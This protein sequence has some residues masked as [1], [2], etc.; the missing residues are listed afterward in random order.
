MSSLHR[1]LRL[2][3]VAVFL[4]SA[5]CASSSAVRYG[6]VAYAPLPAE[7]PVAVFPDDAS[8]GQPYEVIGEV[9]VDNPGKWQVLVASDAISQLSRLAR[10][11]GA[12][13]IIVDDVEQVESGIVSRGY[14]G[15]ARAIRLFGPPPPRGAVAVP[16]AQTA[17][18]VVPVR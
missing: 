5:A 18:A 7:A 17:S 4:S 1:L 8:V 10:G 13:G 12:N 2:A 6:N 16:V 15:R 11:L 3:G 9:E 14:A